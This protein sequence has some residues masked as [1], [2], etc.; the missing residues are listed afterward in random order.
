M[1]AKRV[2]LLI[3]FALV[4]VIAFTQFIVEDD[5]YVKFDHLNVKSGLSN[6][7]ILDIFQ[8]SEGYLWIATRNG[9]N[10]YDGYNFNVFKNMFDE[11]K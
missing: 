1:I 5:P 10:R 4:N 6:N 9:L 7:Y 8:D 3:I 11:L 2:W